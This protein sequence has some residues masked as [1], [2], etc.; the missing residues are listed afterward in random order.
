MFQFQEQSAQHRKSSVDE[1]HPLSPTAETKDSITGT[2]SSVGESLHESSEY[3]TESCI[4]EKESC[5][6]DIRSFPPRDGPAVAST[7]QSSTL[8][9]NSLASNEVLSCRRNHSRNKRKYF[10]QSWEAPRQTKPYCVCHKGCDLLDMIKCDICGIWY[11]C[12]C[13]GVSLPSHS[14]NSKSNN[15]IF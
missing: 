2:E 9:G 13:V 1:M 5:V 15:I 3:E 14:T 12:A 6:D 4:G 10:N 11:H 7:L 8:E